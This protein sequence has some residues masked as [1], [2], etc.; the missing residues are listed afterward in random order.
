MTFAIFWGQIETEMLDFYNNPPPLKNPRD[1]KP[2]QTFET[3][4]NYSWGLIGL[5]QS[6]SAS[7]S[8]Q[9][10]RRSTSI[11]LSFFFSLLQFPPNQSPV[12]GE[13]YL[14]EFEEGIWAPLGGFSSRSR[15]RSLTD[16]RDWAETESD[17]S[18]CTRGTKHFIKSTVREPPLRQTRAQKQDDNKKKRLNSVSSINTCVESCPF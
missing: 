10:K 12:S 6:I 17:K 11:F 15:V 13:V 4:A 3:E 2:S 14:W 1:K 7:H 8:E 9:I 5:F 16:Q 18:V